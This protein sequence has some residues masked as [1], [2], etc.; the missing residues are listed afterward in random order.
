MVHGAEAEGREVSDEPIIWC[1]E[2]RCCTVHDGKCDGDCHLN[3]HYN[4]T[5]DD[6]ED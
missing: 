5:A 2:C 3:G 6:E 4:V 1:Q